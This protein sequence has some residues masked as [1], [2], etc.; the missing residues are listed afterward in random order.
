MEWKPIAEAKACK[1]YL[2]YWR[3]LIDGKPEDFIDEFRVAA[4]E[5]FSFN[6]DGSVREWAWQC[7][8]SDGATKFRIPTP[9]HFC[10]CLAVPAANDNATL[11]PRVACQP[12]VYVHII[13]RIRPCRPTTDMQANREFPELGRLRART[14]GVFWV[15]SHRG[16]YDQRRP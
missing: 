2:V 12:G 6:P 16:V 4:L 1:E 13:L 7:V 9:T 5:S 14:K 10:D 15:R 3:D 11:A 8:G